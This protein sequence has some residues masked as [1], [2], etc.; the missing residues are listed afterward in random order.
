VRFG[1]QRNPIKG[2]QSKGEKQRGRALW[3]WI[4]L[5]NAITEKVTVSR[6]VEDAVRE[7]MISMGEI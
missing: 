7:E 1:G 6:K 4:W 2:K 3:F 5:H